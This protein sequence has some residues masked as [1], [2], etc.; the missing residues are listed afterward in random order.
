M[1][2]ALDNLPRAPTAHNIGW[3]ARCASVAVT[4]LSNLA[5]GLAIGQ[6]LDLQPQPGRF[7]EVICRV[8]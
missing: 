2:T 1:E 7:S 4:L 6:T 8:E 3:R 5:T